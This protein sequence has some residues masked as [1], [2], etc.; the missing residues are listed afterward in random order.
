MQIFVNDFGAKLGDSV[1]LAC[2]EDS[3]V[4][5]SKAL[6]IAYGRARKR[7]KPQYLYIVRHGRV[8]ERVDI[9]VSLG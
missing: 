5:I 6:D 2:Y 3:S 8:S 1:E 9:A 7:G 4:S